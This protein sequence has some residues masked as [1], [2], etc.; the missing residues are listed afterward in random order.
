MQKKYR[1]EWKYCC[2]EY[3][4][5]QLKKRLQDFMMR[6]SNSDKDGIYEVRSLYFDDRNYSCAMAVNAGASHRFK[7]RLRY[8]G[9]KIDTLHLELKEKIYGKSHKSTFNISKELFDKLMNGNEWDVFW[10]T[11]SNLMK[12]FCLDIGTREFSPKI[13]TKYEREAFV[14][15]NLNIR[16]TIDRHV[17][18]SK[19]VDEFLQEDYKY[20]LPLQ[21]TNMH[22][23]EVKFDELLPSYMHKL[24]NMMGI[25]QT[26]FSKY[27]IGLKVTGRK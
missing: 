4:L 25:S 11:D 22:V 10:N 8:Y 1:N 6:D 26:S 18:A 19:K 13:I 23:L 21:K 9:N 12:R 27:Y 20:S 7:Y 5:E 24:I 3:Y 17:C 2:S 15:P 16:V 14:E